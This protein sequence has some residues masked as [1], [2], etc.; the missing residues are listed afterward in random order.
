MVT[1]NSFLMIFD[2]HSSIVLTFSI[3][4]Y[5][6]CTLTCPNYGI[7]SIIY[8]ESSFVFLS[9]MIIFIVADSAD[10]D[11]MPPYA[12]FHL[13]LDCLLK[14]LFTRIQNEKGST[15]CLL[16]ATFVIC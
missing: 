5:L 1:K 12:A 15:P 6:V 3:A 2:L 14:Y 10:P 16:W 8:F 13:G 11:E 7:V 9:L 4:T